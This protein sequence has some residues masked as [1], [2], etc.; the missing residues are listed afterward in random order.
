MAGPTSLKIHWATG[1]LKLSR[2]LK[3]AA[4]KPSY[5]HHGPNF[6][7]E[8]FGASD[9]LVQANAYK[10]DRCYCVQVLTA[11]PKPTTKEINKTLTTKKNQS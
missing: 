9:S 6:T 11:P 5:F 3:L 8:L 2:G 4:V 1:T 7:V 10:K